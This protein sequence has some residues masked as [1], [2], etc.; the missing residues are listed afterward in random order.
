[1]AERKDI[2]GEISELDI[3]KLLGTSGI[4]A[5]AYCRND[6]YF[7]LIISQSKFQVVVLV[8]SAVL[9]KGRVALIWVT[10]HKDAKPVSGASVTLYTPKVFNQRILHSKTFLCLGKRLQRC[11]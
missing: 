5:S 1:M 7:P 10:N 8:S 11:S 9:P 6:V 4:V 3:S 2:A